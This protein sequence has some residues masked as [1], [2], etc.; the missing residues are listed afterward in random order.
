MRVFRIRWIY[1]KKFS[2]NVKRIHLMIRYI[3]KLQGPNRQQTVLDIFEDMP[4]VKIR[5]KSEIYITVECAQEY[6][7]VLCE[8]FIKNGHGIARIA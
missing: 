7:R 2:A 3:A 8:H 6:E 4:L 5:E 1:G